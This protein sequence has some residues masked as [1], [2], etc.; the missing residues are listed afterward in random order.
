[1]AERRYSPGHQ[2][3]DV[4]THAEIGGQG[5][6]KEAAGLIRLDIPEGLSLS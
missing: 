2:F 4:V 1:M 3:A 5:C 6:A